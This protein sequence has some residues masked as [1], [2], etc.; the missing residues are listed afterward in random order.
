MCDGRAAGRAGGRG[1]G[2]RAGGGPDKASGPLRRDDPETTPPEPACRQCLSR[3]VPPPHGQTSL[4]RVCEQHFCIAHL[5][6][7]WWMCVPPELRQGGPDIAAGVGLS[8]GAAFLE[9]VRRWATSPAPA[10]FFASRSAA[11]RGV[12]EARGFNNELV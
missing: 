12:G 8:P 6:D 5:E 11:P 2:G 7:H 4:C 9:G 1:P 3:R 10:A